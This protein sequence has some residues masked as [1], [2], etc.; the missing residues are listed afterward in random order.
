MRIM[1]GNQAAAMIGA[2]PTVGVI[3]AA[4]GPEPPAAIAEAHG[5]VVRGLRVAVDRALVV[6][7]R[8]PVVVLVHGQ[9]AV[10]DPA[11]AQARVLAGRETAVMHG[12]RIG[13]RPR[14]VRHQ[15]PPLLRCESSFSRR[16]T[17][18]AA[19]RDRSSKAVVPTRS[20]EQ[21]ASFWSAPSAIG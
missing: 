9:V 15:R 6:V 4:H 14:I 3:D 7:G 10:S 12:L 5:Q 17:A 21:D 16:R 19:S 18:P 8:V 13:A 1:R 11:V 20:L 2:L